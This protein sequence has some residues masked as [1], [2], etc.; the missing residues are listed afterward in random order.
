MKRKKKTSE[1]DEV[2]NW[3]DTEEESFLTD[4]DDS[5]DEDWRATPMYKRKATKRKTGSV[6]NASINDRSTVDKSANETSQLTRV[7]II[8]VK[9]SSYCSYCTF[10]P[11][12]TS[13]QIILSWKS[14][15][16][17]TIIDLIV[18]EFN[19]IPLVL[20]GYKY[21]YQCAVE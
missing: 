5:S 4:N 11:K 6:D 16:P 18:L 12:R 9:C 1:D 7:S 2:E 13:L 21:W 20:T 3:E 17:C 15:E 8:I 10:P 14:A 19:G